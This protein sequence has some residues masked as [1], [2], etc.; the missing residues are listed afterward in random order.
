M[1]L[2]LFSGAVG[3][4]GSSGSTYGRFEFPDF[5]LSGQAV[6]QLPEGGEQPGAVGLQ[7]TLLAAEPEL[8][9]EPVALQKWNLISLGGGSLMINTVDT[10]PKG[11]GINSSHLQSF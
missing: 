9:G 8:D 7:L 2:G 6:L 11:P 10:W 5:R 3:L 1:P 4:L